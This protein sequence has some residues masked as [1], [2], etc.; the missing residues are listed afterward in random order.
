MELNR[1][2]PYSSIRTEAGGRLV[3]ALLAAIE[4]GFPV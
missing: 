3:E 2:T 1:A 4:Y